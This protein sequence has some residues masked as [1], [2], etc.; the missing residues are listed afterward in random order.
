MSNPRKSTVELPREIAAHK[1]SMMLHFNVGNFRMALLRA[2]QGIC[3]VNRKELDYQ[4]DADDFH[5]YRVRCLSE[6]GLHA[7]AEAAQE[8]YKSLVKLYFRLMGVDP[9]S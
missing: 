4:E 5:R 1:I 6:L 8:Q 7:E 2:N 9:E 3:F